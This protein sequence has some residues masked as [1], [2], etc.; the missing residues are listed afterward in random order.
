MV[1]DGEIKSAIAPALETHIVPQAYP[2]TNILSPTVPKQ[3]KKF[4]HQ[5]G[6]ALNPLNATTTKES[7]LFT[8]WQALMPEGKG[9]ISPFKED[10]IP[11]L[12]DGIWSP[13]ASEYLWEI[14]VFHQ[15]GCLVYSPL[16][17]P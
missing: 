12:P 5:H 1:H 15:L 2:W 3:L 8:K 13:S 16:Q 17:A 14:S 4:Q 6:Y 7:L 9:L 11:T 10:T